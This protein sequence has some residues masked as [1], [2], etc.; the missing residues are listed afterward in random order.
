MT[1]FEKQ[2]II[3]NLVKFEK[4]MILEDDFPKLSF[5]RKIFSERMVN[6]IVRTD[7]SSLDFETFTS[8][9]RCIY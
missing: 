9:P 8:W 5:R 2:K 7:S 4:C 6:Y 3:W 1:G